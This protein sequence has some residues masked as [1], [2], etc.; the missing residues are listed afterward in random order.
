MRTSLPSKTTSSKS[1]T[2]G[3][4]FKFKTDGADE[5]GSSIWARLEPTNIQANKK[6]EVGSEAHIK[7]SAEETKGPAAAAPEY[8]TSTKKKQKKKKKPKQN[9]QAGVKPED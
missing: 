8:Q 2:Q 3:A 6:V 4:V 1:N 9:Q 7:S 5:P